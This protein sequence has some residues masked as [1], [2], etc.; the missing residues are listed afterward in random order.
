MFTTTQVTHIL[1]NQCY[2]DLNLLTVDQL[3]KLKLGEFMFRVVKGDSPI[4]QDII[5]ELQWSHYY[6]TRRVEPLRNPRVESAY[7]TRTFTYNMIKLW[8]KLKISKEIENY[9]SLPCFKKALKQEI[10]TLS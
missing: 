1:T 4:R 8:N 5:S 9:T 3:Y 2:N 10:K 6:N 7:E